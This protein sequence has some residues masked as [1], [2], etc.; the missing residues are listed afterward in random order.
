[1]TTIY[2]MMDVD[3]L[4]LYFVKESIIQADDVG[5][6]KA[7]TTT[8][9]QVQKLLQHISGPGNVKSFHAMLYVMEEHGKQA[10]RV[11]Y[12]NETTLHY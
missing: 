8:K 6:I 5:V 10:T 11:R 12:F 9:D 3:N 7:L 1:M 4:L 2:T